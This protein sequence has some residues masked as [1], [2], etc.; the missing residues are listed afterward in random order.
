[1]GTTASATKFKEVLMRY[2]IFLLLFATSPTEEAVQ[3]DTW[4]L[5]GRY[6]WGAPCGVSEDFYEGVCEV[7]AMK[8]KRRRK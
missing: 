5:N 7:P 3:P 1:M 4:E 2:L 6:M 8:E